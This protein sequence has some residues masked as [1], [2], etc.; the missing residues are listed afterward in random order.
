MSQ[1]M[2]FGVFISN[3]DGGNNYVNNF[4]P[5]ILSSFN[6]VIKQVLFL[7]KFD[8]GDGRKLF[9]RLK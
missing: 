5:T 6:Q 8:I 2:P 3:P 1:N 7:L 9:K 4:Y